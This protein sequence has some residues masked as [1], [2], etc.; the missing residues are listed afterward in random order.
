MIIC[1]SGS[2]SLQ[3]R[4]QKPD[5]ITDAVMRRCRAAKKT[6]DPFQKEQIITHLK[7]LKKRKD[8]EQATLDQYQSEVCFLTQSLKIS[9]SHNPTPTRHT[10][11]HIHVHTHTYT[12]DRSSTFMCASL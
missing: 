7:R 6:Q 2:R 4:Y 8:E 11:I 12:T 3:R 9:A 5:A 10:H 1:F